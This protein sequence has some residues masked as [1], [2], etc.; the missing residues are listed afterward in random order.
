VRKSDGYYVLDLLPESDGFAV[1]DRR[2]AVSDWDL[3]GFRGSLLRCCE[4]VLGATLISEAWLHHLPDQLAD[5]G[6]RL[7]ACA[8]AYAR[9]HDVSHILNG[10]CFAWEEEVESNDT[11]SPQQ[12]ALVI[13]SAARW[14]VLW[15]SRGHG[16]N[17]DY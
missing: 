4:D 8:L 14:A 15:S 12:K 17:A 6:E 16:L 1:A 2:V 7:M 3:V 9:D 5:S 13:A 11:I 10:R